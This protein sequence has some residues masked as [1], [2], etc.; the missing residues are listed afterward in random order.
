M[1]HAWDGI[2]WLERD[3]GMEFFMTGDGATEARP[4]KQGLEAEV[5][6]IVLPHASA[7]L[8]IWNRGSHADV[9]MQYRVMKAL[10]SGGIA[11]P[12]PL[13]WG[14]NLEGH[15]AL[16]TS[17]EG[18]PMEGADQ[19]RLE[20]LAAILR[21]V[22]HFPAERLH[23]LPRYDFAGYFF[24]GVS[25]FPE[26]AEALADL[27][28]KARLRQDKLIHGD[29]HLGN[30]VE[31]RGKLSVIDWTNVQLGD[32]R[33]DVAWPYVLGL[34]YISGQQARAFLDAYLA[35]D[36]ADGKELSLFEGIAF[37]RWALLLRRGDLPAESSA[38]DNARRLI[39]NNNQLSR[40]AARQLLGA[41]ADS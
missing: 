18:E 3:A 16:L 14:R 8:K 37:L 1:K 28:G 32:A 24:P 23:N 25:R 15:A 39:R 26:L 4:M 34:I 13:G 19:K 29:Y 30:V 6:R 2:Q 17:Y 21:G 7:V 12:R 20:E 33:Y 11:V 38:L 9:S 5:L 40:Y 31:D 35:S 22:H 41:Y 36:S 27:T 10:S